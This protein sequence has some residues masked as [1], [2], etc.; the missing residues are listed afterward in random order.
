MPLY[1]SIQAGCAQM[2]APL[3]ILLSE[4]SS[5]SAR[6]SITAL[7]I[8]GY[9]VDVCDPDSLCLG[10]FS[11]FVGRYYRCPAVGRNPWVYL[12]FVCSLLARGQHDVLF[13]AHEQAFLFS[14]TRR[15]IPPQVALA[16]PEFKSFLRVQSKSALVRTLTELSI[17][18]P[19]SLIIRTEAELLEGHPLP[20]FLKTDYGTASTGTWRVSNREA[21]TKLVPLLKLKGLFDA[22]SELVIQAAARGDV[23]RVQAVF[24][25]GRLVAI[26]GFRQLME[27]LGGGDV[28]KLS[29]VRSDVRHYVESLGQHLS[30]HGALS[31]DYILEQNAR[32]PVFIDANPRLVEP[33]NGVF[34]G[35]N[36]ADLLVRVSL[37]EKVSVPEPSQQ[38]VR[39]HMLLMGLLAAAEQRASRVDT[40]R[41]LYRALTSR[42][43]YAASR[44]ELLPIRL[45]AGALVPFGY[46][47]SRLLVN[48]R[49]ART[50]SLGAISSYS[51]TPE[52]MRQIAINQTPDES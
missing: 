48:P 13:P 20:F 45:D 37:G 4:G 43:P 23:E 14:R 26:H 24:D 3:R 9:R 42:G 19:E 33:M 50:L 44:E 5:L 10:R 38:G 21:L 29:V 32:V 47:L 30:W 34:S 12:D 25:A 28:A 17:P 35:V 6:E 2:S 51:L 52:A 22:G 36:L 18:Q 15:Q 1:A 11:R 7:G 27:G 8:A 39:T 16:V 46:V 40:L 41:E 31:L 49:S